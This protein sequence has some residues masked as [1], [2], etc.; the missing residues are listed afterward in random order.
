MWQTHIL[1]DVVASLDNDSGY[2]FPREEL[3]KKFLDPRNFIKIKKWVDDQKSQLR[4]ERQLKNQTGAP[5]KSRAKPTELQATRDAAL[6]DSRQMTYGIST[7]ESKRGDTTPPPA[8]YNES[9]EHSDSG[10]Q[11]SIGGSAAAPGASVDLSNTPDNVDGDG[12]GRDGR[13]RKGKGKA[14]DIPPAGVEGVGGSGSGG[15]SSKPEVGAQEEHETS[16]ESDDEGSYLSDTVAEAGFSQSSPGPSPG[17]PSENTRSKR[18]VTPLRD[19]GRKKKKNKTKDFD[20]KSV[21][22]FLSEGQ[23]RS[24]EQNSSQ[25]KEIRGIATGIEGA[26]N[27]LNARDGGGGSGESAAVAERK[28]RC[29][30][31]RVNMEH[32]KMLV[33]MKEKKIGV[34]PTDEEIAD[35]LAATKVRAID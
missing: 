20:S 1:T 7:I 30:G 29:E 9:Q 24:A 22:D 18:D 25:L 10:L 5:A 19:R 13:G 32:L 11:A 4:K 34:V 17:T 33:M 16:E 31:A 27:S 12:R 28:L 21:G 14:R 8:R 6:G 15:S 2:P 26:I 3:E 35:A 23:E